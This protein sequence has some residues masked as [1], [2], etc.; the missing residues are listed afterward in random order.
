MQ[1]EIKSDSI[2]EAIQQHLDQTVREGINYRVKDAL[3]KAIA[4]AITPEVV[5]SYVEAAMQALTDPEITKRIVT[6]MQLA[7]A[8][9]VRLTMQEAIVS[10]AARLR[11][12]NVNRNREDEQKLEDLRA[13]LFPRIAQPATPTLAHE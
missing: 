1:L 2:R 13:R 8:E 10:V 5:T 11:G 4:D 7:I 6:E 12:Y 3:N 9:G